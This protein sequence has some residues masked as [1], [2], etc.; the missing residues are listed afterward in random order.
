LSILSQ[1]TSQPPLQRLE[2][3]PAIKNDKNFKVKLSISIPMDPCLLVDCCQL[4]EL[5][6]K[7]GQLLL[8]F[9][10]QNKLQ[11]LQ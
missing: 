9:Y 8:A 6:S 2:K 11:P 10:W 5:A 7:N 1:E 3:A 4:V